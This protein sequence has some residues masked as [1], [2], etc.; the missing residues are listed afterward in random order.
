MVSDFTHLLSVDLS[1][2]AILN[3]PFYGFFQNQLTLLLAQFHCHSRCFGGH[4]RTTYFGCWTVL[5]AIWFNIN[6]VSSVGSRFFRFLTVEINNYFSFF[7]LPL[8][9][10]H[11]KIS[12]VNG[13]D[14]IFQVSFAYL[15]EVK[16]LTL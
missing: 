9:Y 3:F 13:M 10:D 6:L 8:V 11:W 15:T 12:N 2:Y 4:P 7:A 16:L 5:T 1:G 14:Q